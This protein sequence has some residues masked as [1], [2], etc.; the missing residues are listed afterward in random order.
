[1]I[2]RIIMVIVAVIALTAANAQSTEQL[3]IKNGKV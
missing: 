1:M 2:R 3:V